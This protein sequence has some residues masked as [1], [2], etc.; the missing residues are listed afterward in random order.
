MVG[1]VDT[2]LLHAGC[3]PWGASGGAALSITLG[4]SGECSQDGSKGDPFCS[5][6]LQS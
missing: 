5:M 6:Q 3:I 1:G 2:R 4:V